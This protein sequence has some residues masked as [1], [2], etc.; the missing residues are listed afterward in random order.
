MQFIRRVYSMNRAGHYPGITFPQ[1]L[2]KMISE[3]VILEQVP[4]GILVRPA[5][6]ESV[7]SG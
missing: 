5:R 4:E 2:A 1:E 6:I 3:F 7:H